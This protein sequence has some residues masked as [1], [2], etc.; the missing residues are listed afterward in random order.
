MSYT[1]VLNFVSLLSRG[2]VDQGLVGFEFSG[3]DYTLVLSAIM[4]AH[5][6]HHQ[7]NNNNGP[8]L[9]V[10]LSKLCWVPRPNPKQLDDNL[11]FFLECAKAVDEKKSCTSS[12]S[13]S[14][15]TRLVAFPGEIETRS[16]GGARRGIVPFLPQEQ[17]QQQQPMMGNKPAAQ[18][19][20]SGG[21]CGD[22]V[23]SN[24]SCEAQSHHQ[25]QQNA[26]TDDAGKKSF[27]LLLFT[28]DTLQPTKNC[29]MHHMQVQKWFFQLAAAAAATMSD[30]ITSDVA[31]NN[32]NNINSA[33]QQRWFLPPSH[34]AAAS[35]SFS[36][37]FSTFDPLAVRRKYAMPVPLSQRCPAPMQE[38]FELIAAEKQGY[39]QCWREME[40]CVLT[41]LARDAEVDMRKLHNV[42]LSTQPTRVL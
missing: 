3:L 40:K 35:G 29:F 32:N 12:A 27:S 26:T 24:I 10:D 33:H 22:D 42:L 37:L 16:F 38:A 25:Q 17:Q 34:S 31:L 8:P 36:S 39:R 6:H 41:M 2:C 28:P 30:S 7:N 13:T 15:S 4:S 5:H 18:N 19:N 11:V 14:S 23:A 1:E 9:V 21:G 20:T